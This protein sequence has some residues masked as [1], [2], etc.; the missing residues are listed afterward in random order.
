MLW[1][2]G[3]DVAQ[4]GDEVLGVLLDGWSFGEAAEADEEIGGLAGFEVGDA[5]ADHDGFGVWVG[6]FVAGDDFGFAAVAGGWGAVVEVDVVAVVV[7]DEGHG[8]DGIDAEVLGEWADRVGEPA[9]ED[10][11]FPACGLRGLDGFGGGG[12]DVADVE[13]ADG[14]AITARRADGV[15]ASGEDVIDGDGAVHGLIGE[16]FDLGECGGSLGAG[17]FVDSLDSGKGGVAV[18]EE[19]LVVGHRGEGIKDW[20]LLDAV[21]YRRSFGIMSYQFYQILHMVGLI[22]FLLG[23]GGAI[24]AAKDAF[25]P[26][27]ILHGTG[28]FVMVVAGFGMQAKGDLGFP[29]WLIAKLVIW[30]ILGGML[31]LA[32]RDALPRAAIWATVIVLGGVAAL[33]GVTKGAWLVL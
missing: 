27:A 33:L 11:D 22:V 3:E 25:K 31:V 29:W 24:A 5:V 10:D 9:G 2:Q 15:E 23:L 21:G 19:E 4:R 1:Q 12:L 18:E 20:S 16:R 17:E 26:Y 30:M 32:K 28:L 6:G 8:F 7:E 14:M 13:L